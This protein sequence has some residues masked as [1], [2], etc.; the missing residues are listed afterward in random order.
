MLN[1]ALKWGCPFFQPSSKFTFVLGNL[2]SPHSS[3]PSPRRQQHL[4]TAASRPSIARPR[5]PLRSLPS[6]PPLLHLLLKVILEEDLKFLQRPSR[7]ITHHGPGYP[8]KSREKRLLKSTG[9][10][11]P[12]RAARPGLTLR[13]CPLSPA[14]PGT[15][16]PAGPQAGQI[17]VAFL[18]SEALEGLF[19]CN[20]SYD[21]V[22]RV[23]F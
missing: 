14:S 16:A 6:L 1:N 11:S 21:F 17:R 2:L 8:S 13:I 19:G 23:T 7:S 20:I 9:K 4:P 5:Q 12:G 15:G 18:P 10:P 3:V 22:L